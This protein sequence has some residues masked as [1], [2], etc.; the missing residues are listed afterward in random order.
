[1]R[2]SA[3]SAAI[4][5]GDYRLDNVMFDAERRRIVAVLDWEMATVGDPLTDLGLL[6][7]YAALAEVGLGPAAPFPLSSGFPPLAELVAGYATRRPVRVAALNW[8]VALGYYKLAV[9]SEGIHHRFL[10]GQT[11]G[12]GFAAMG[13]QVPELVSRAHRALTE[14]DGW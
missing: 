5:H 8:Y 10:A 2:G 9:V 13:E 11:V 14:G 4:W 12:E 6:Y 7:V 3:T 1:M